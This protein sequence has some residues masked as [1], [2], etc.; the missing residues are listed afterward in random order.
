[1]LANKN[2]LR[3]ELTW[4]V[5][6]LA[7]SISITAWEWVLRENNM[8][9][10]L[11]HYDDDVCTKREIVKITAK[12][13]D[14][15]TITRWFAVCIMND[16]TKQQWQWSQTFSAW[17]YLS[18][19]LN[20]EIR[21]SL[22]VWITNNQ[23]DI[24]TMTARITAPRNCINN[25]CQSRKNAIDCAYVEKYWWNAWFWTWSDGDCVIENDTFLCAS[26]EYN[27]NN[28]TICPNATVRFC[29]SWVPTINVRNNFK[30]YWTIDMRAPYIQAW[31]TQQ[32][33]CRLFNWCCVWNQTD[34]LTWIADVWWLYCWNG[35]WSQASSWHWWN[36][37]TCWTCYDWINWWN[38]WTNWCSWTWWWWWFWMWKWWNWWVWNCSWWPWWN[39]FYWWNWWNVCQRSRFNWWWWAWWTW[40]IRWWDAWWWIWSCDY[41]EM[42]NGWNAITNVYWL[43]LNARNIRNNCVNAR[44]WDWWNWWWYCRTWTSWW[45]APS[46]WNWWNGANWWQMM[47]SYDCIHEQWCFDVSWWSWWKWWRIKFTNESY[48]RYVQPDWTN[49]SDWRVVFKSLNNPY[50]ENFDLVNDDTNEAVLISW[51][52][53]SFK[54]SST[55]Q[56]SKTIVRYSTVNYPSTITDWTLAIEETTKDQYSTTPYSLT[57]LSDWTTYYFTAFAVDQNNTMIDVQTNSITP[58]FVFPIPTNT[59]AYY[60]LTAD[61]NDSSWH[62]RNLSVWSWITFSSS[63][64]AYLPNSRHTWMVEPFNITSSWTRTIIRRQ[65]TLWIVD[66]DARWIDIYFNSSNRICS[67]WSNNQQKFYIK[68][69]INKPYSESSNTRYNHIITISNWTVKLYVDNSLRYT[70]S[71]NTWLTSSYF[72]RGQEYNNA[73]NRQLYWYLKGIIVENKVYTDAE[74]NKY[75]NWIKAQYWK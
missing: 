6:V 59:Y 10:C 68:T 19:Y 63:N 28:L 22:T 8:I 17:D 46:W 26:C 40:V 49:W 45:Y 75:R 73:Y 25:N 50:I 55:Q 38:W 1:M 47:I 51:K 64:G 74:R 66:S 60:T 65:K 35:W 11:E 43:H 21:E 36:W 62:N 57:W 27:F 72:R 7:T 5:S 33:D 9:A 14:T 16:Q 71:I 3:S 30:N 67:L 37:W 54:P 23:D 20:K 41:T 12:N 34:S 58:S 4:S 29:W 53:P 39:W 70:W 42:W 32:T 44:W 13:T 61:W 69:D 15:F 52:D 48:C 56:R 18:L 24:D 2:N 31:N